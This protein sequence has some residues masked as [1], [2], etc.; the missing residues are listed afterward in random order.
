MKRYYDILKV[1]YM[2]ADGV[3]ALSVL[4]QKVSLTVA[5]GYAFDELPLLRSAMTLEVS[6]EVTDAGRIYS[7][8]L[9][10]IVEDGFS[11]SPLKRESVVL[12]I[13]DTDGVEY[14]IGSPDYR[15]VVTSEY[16]NKVA[17][18]T[19][20]RKLTFSARQDYDVLP[21]SYGTYVPVGKFIVSPD[22]VELAA[23]QG[24]S[25]SYDIQPATASKKK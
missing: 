10:A 9:S 3:A 21:L 19:L 18:G 24:V 17:A 15:G 11:I 6:D 23:G 20:G 13:T 4:G 16:S 7:A 22:A 5:P 1:E 14:L 12:R 8:S 2:P 25:V